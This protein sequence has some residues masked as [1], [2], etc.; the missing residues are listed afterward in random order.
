M[1]A[2]IN[3]DEVTFK[4]SIFDQEESTSEST[5]FLAKKQ[6]AINEQVKGMTNVF[7][8]LR[9]D[10][11]DT[12]PDWQ[13]MLLN[14]KDSREKMEVRITRERWQEEQKYKLFEEAQAIREGKVNGVLSTPPNLRN[15]FFYD[16]LQKNDP[17]TYWDNK[18]QRQRLN[19]KKSLGLG[20]HLRSK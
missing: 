11:S 7:H 3:D 17:N 6:N 19:D 9:K 12:E 18:V 1:A 20:F 13:R 4:T 15:K 5:A 16:E 8:D 14:A 2:I 10:D